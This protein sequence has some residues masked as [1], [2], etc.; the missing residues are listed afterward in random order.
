M[1]SSISDSDS[2]A[3]VE[4]LD[5]SALDELGPTVLVKLG[6][7]VMGLP[8]K[9]GGARRSTTWMISAIVL[10]SNPEVEG[11][12]MC[13]LVLSLTT[14]APLHAL[15]LGTSALWSAG[16][17]AKLELGGRSGTFGVVGLLTGTKLV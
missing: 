6:L 9:F 2:N 15:D 1:I 8:E 17:R 12:D 13:V 5:W 4:G 11:S 16:M 10:G 7:A 14:S 3:K